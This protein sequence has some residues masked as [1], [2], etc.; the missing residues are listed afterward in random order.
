MKKITLL[1]FSILI[2]N[3]Q[4]QPVKTIFPGLSDEE[5]NVLLSGLLLNQ[6]YNDN[7]DGTITD[8]SFNLVWQK[9]TQGQVY[10]SGSNDCEGIQRPSVTNPFFTQGADTINWGARQLAYCSNATN[11]CNQLS[12]PQ[13]LQGDS[14]II[15]TGISEAFQSCNSLNPP[16][17]NSAT[18]WR[19]PNPLELERLTLG[20]R[21]ALIAVHFPNT[22][23]DYYWSSW[24]NPEDLIGQT[25]TAVIF[26]RKRFGEKELRI[27]TD[28]YYV[29]C[30]R[31]K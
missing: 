10:R 6:G 5:L 21:N 17:S 13:T 4:E 2:L 28:R 7:R 26:E 12:I 15:V 11:A 1:I 29:R 22:I 30:V 20:G 31:N 9:C 27:K 3:C 16:N 19:V 14:S 23:E 18:A 25:A 8:N 24:S